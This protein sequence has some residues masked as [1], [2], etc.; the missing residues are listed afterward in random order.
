MLRTRRVWQDI[1][2][3]K[4]PRRPSG[5]LSTP[6]CALILGASMIARF[7]FATDNATLVRWNL[8][9]SGGW[10]ALTIDEH[11][12][13]LYVTHSDRVLVVD[14]KDGTVAGTIPDTDGVHGVAIDTGSGK[15]YTSNGRGDSVTEFD[16]K[17]LK[18][19]RVIPVPGH[20]PDAI[21]FDASTKEVWAF[22]GKSHDATAIDARTVRVVA[23][24]P[25]DGKPEFAVVDGRG[26]IFVNDE[27]HAKLIVIDAKARR[28]VATWKL[29]GCESPSGIALDAARHRLF[30][31]C[32]NEHMIVTDSKSGRHVATV[33][34]G[35][36][37]DGVAYDPDR[38]LVF[39][40]NGR[41]GTLSVIRQVD[42]D[43]YEVAATLPTQQS[44]RTI[45]LDATT[46]TVYLPAATLGPTPAPTAEQPRPRPSIVPDSFC[47]LVVAPGDIAHRK[48]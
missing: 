16:L 43:N 29:E 35:K 21:V 22:N 1:R 27:D 39:S 12:H 7:A 41:D 15:G 42:A 32:D 19:E 23:T 14:T 11:A 20:N 13:R 31:A 4:L 2:N 48:S 5:R 26:R 40:P 8:G 38:R 9:G 18:T 45:A 10:D 36:G 24:V 17:S 30:S 34:I 25:L 46:H 47:I 44:A 33:P 6:A 37:P 28:V 3:M